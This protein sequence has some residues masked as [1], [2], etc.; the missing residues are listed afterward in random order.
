[1]RVALCDDEHVHIKSITQMLGEYR[2]PDGSSVLV[3]QYDNAIELISN[4]KKI[5][6]DAL[7]LDIVMPGF[8]GI[9]AARDIRVD[10]MSIPIVFLTN[11]PEF[12]VDSY[13]VHAL[14]YLMKPV[15]AD[16]LYTTLNHIFA[17]C[18][19]KKKDLLTINSA[20][21]VHT[22]SYEQLVFVE[23][24]NGVLSFYTLDGNVKTVRGKLSEYEGEL[25]RRNSFIKVHRS[26]IINMDNMKSYDR[27]NFT[28]MTGQ[29][30]PV[31]RNISKEVQDE[32]LDYLYGMVRK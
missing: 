19:R 21:E 12:A 13:R 29:I 8:T 10:N 17:L 1:M 30:I 31:S 4:I 7:L 15:K 26:Y 23:I 25:L 5:D 14:D 32:Y 9:E 6:Y 24:N 20:K 28:A 16:D 2:A 3:D 27:K 11:S 22:I 18:D